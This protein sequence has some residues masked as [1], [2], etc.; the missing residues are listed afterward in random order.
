MSKSRLVLALVFATIMVLIVP[1][2]LPEIA[3]PALIPGASAAAHSGFVIGA[4]LLAAA[5]SFWRG[6]PA[7]AVLLLV[8]LH[9]TRMGVVA[10]GPPLAPA[11]RIGL[12]AALVLG[13]AGA[14]RRWP[15][16]R[17]A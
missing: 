5:I 14:F 17:A 3:S 16:E 2:L 10:A 1:M 7:L 12:A 11:A 13:T 9:A 6:W 8:V 4:V 15:S